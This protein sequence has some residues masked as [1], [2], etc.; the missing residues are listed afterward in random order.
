[1]VI[2]VS[3]V[4][5]KRERPSAPWERT[6]IDRSEYEVDGSESDSFPTVV[7]DRTD[8]GEPLRLITFDV[9]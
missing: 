3:V 9:S 2:T 8:K 6:I 5:C 7:T 4:E 1:M